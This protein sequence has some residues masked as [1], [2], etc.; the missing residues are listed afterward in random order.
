MSLEGSITELF[1]RLAHFSAFPKY[2]VERRVD[3]FLALFIEEFLS[4]QYDAPVRIIAPEFP[5]KREAS[6]QSIHVDYL[7]RRDGPRPAWLFLELKT[8]ADSFRDPQLEAY[9]RARA[10]GMPA[11][12]RDLHT[13]Q[14]ASDHREKYAH[15]LQVVEREAPVDVEC[16]VVYLSPALHWPLPEQVRV[17]TLDTLAAWSPRN[18]HVELW[19]H[20][21][22]LLESL[23][24]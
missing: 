4:D 21:R 5:L 15:L 19:P 9:L 8:S 24:R 23:P 1:A 22:R 16:E 13:I 12:L 18:R 7:L 10:A 17:F 14:R 20:V 2:S 11:L 3:L 6:N